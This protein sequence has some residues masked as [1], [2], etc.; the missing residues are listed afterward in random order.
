MRNDKKKRLIVS[1]CSAPLPS[2]IPTS[3]VSDEIS[4]QTL[5]ARLHLHAVLPALEDLARLSPEARALAKGWDFSL[6]LRLGD[7]AATLVSPGDGSLLVHP[8]ADAPAR[9]TLRFLSAVQLN[10]TFLNRRALPPLPTAG[11][12][13]VGRVGPFTKLAK[14]LDAALQPAPGVLETDAAFRET[15]L[16]L[17]FRVLLG[18]IPVLAGG[19]HVTQHTLS[20]TP[21]GTAEIRAPALESSGWARW[22][23]G[24]MTGGPGPV[25]GGAPDVVITFA[26][27]ETAGAALLGS[28][29]P[30]AAVGLGKVGVR[31]L[32]PLADG[33]S[34]AMDRV[35]RYLK[36]VGAPAVA[37]NAAAG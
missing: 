18:A 1:D 17:L 20:H 14:L 12:W 5:L 15:H 7:T 4:F 21:D 35:E 34:V 28:L 29:D 6:R 37:F 16:R 26:D 27:H 2:A 11:F 32:V 36:P 30:N 13:N 25:P 3:S 19:D 22:S 31:G 24:R 33:L 9:L 10:R 8:H 23:R